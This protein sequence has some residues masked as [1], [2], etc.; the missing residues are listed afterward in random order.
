MADLRQALQPYAPASPLPVAEIAARAGRRRRRRLLQTTGLAAAALGGAAL[1]VTSLTVTT[2]DR[3][4]TDG[5]LAAVADGSPAPHGVAIPSTA[6]LDSGIDVVTTA[7]GA[8]TGSTEIDPGVSRPG[9]SG[10][11]SPL[12]T[13]TGP[14][15]TSA[16]APGERPDPSVT[17]AEVAPGIGVTT[18]TTSSWPGGFCL[19]VDLANT[20]DRPILW[21]VTLDLPGTIDTIWSAVPQPAGAGTVTFR[22]EAGYNE[23]LGGRAATTFGMCLTTGG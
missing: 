14:D 9:P 15:T 17:V 12:V 10:S 7:A 20:T 23:S 13:P 21:Q 18:K 8:P 4:A 2:D 16:A 19:Q 11:E 5:S 1:V 22:G 3:L 6:G